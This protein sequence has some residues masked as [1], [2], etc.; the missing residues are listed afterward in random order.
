V[1]HQYQLQLLAR[2]AIGDFREGSVNLNLQIVPEPAPAGLL[3]IA[4]AGTIFRRSRR[5][6]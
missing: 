5:Q 3:A 1:N 4:L 6:A 2:S